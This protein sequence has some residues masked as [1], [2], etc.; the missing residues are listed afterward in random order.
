ML[1]GIGTQGGVSYDGPQ[2]AKKLGITRERVRQR[3]ERAL[4]RLRDPELAAKLPKGDPDDHADLFLLEVMGVPPSNSLFQ[5]LKRMGRKNLERIWAVLSEEAATAATGLEEL[6]EDSSVSQPNV[7]AVTLPGPFW[8]DRYVIRRVDLEGLPHGRGLLLMVLDGHG[9]PRV[10]EQVYRDFPPFFED[11]MIQTMGD[12]RSSLEGT[13]Q[14]AHEQTRGIEGQGTTVSVTYFP[15]DEKQVYAAVLGDSPVIVRDENGVDHLLPL[16]A[17]KTN[18]A[19]RQRVSRLVEQH[20]RR[21]EGSDSAF[22]HLGGSFIRRFVPVGKEDLRVQDMTVS[23]ALGDNEFDPLLRRQPE[24]FTFSL[25]EGSFVLLGSDGLFSL[26]EQAPPVIEQIDQGAQAPDLAAQAPRRGKDDVTALL[27]RATPLPASAKLEENLPWMELERFVTEYAQTREDLQEVVKEASSAGSTH[28]L[29]VPLYGGP[30]GE[31]EEVVYIHPYYLGQRNPWYKWVE[32]YL[33]EANTKLLKHDIQ[34][35]SLN[36]R[37]NVDFRSPGFLA[38]EPGKR[39]ETPRGYPVLPAFFLKPNDQRKLHPALVV[40]KTLHPKWPL[41]FL[42]K[43]Q[44]KAV[45]RFQNRATGE[46]FLLIMG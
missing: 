44:V 9:G 38:V 23:A 25:G 40:A 42:A 1:F 5:P 28:L 13:F 6:P 20:S 8:E 10:V 26:P 21:A 4:E 24:I 37:G 36:E 14:R 15:D 16:H 12:V 34:F 11:A 39:F 35:N 41:E 33:I 30:P 32:G 46:Y 31:S 19:E 3:K 29:M 45:H 17:V 7:S 18:D 22:F 27:W 43:I 2:I